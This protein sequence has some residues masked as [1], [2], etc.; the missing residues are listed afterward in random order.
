MQDIK[1]M[2]IRVHYHFFPEKKH[3]L[4]IL[5]TDEIYL[6]DTKTMWLDLPPLP[7]K[8]IMTGNNMSRFCI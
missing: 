2:F 5:K 6:L 4:W 1:V 8:K 7:P 3:L